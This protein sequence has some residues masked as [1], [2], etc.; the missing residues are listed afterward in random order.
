[1]FYSL[2]D[3]ALRVAHDAARV[4]YGNHRALGLDVVEDPETMRC[5]NFPQLHL[6]AVVGVT[7]SGEDV[8]AAAP[9]R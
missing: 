4:L 5:V 8:Q 1:M 7:V 3:Q 2:D 6:N 9:R